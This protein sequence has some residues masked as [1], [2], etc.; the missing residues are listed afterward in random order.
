MNIDCN[1]KGHNKAGTSPCPGLELW[2]ASQGNSFPFW[3]DLWHGCATY[4]GGMCP[5][6][7][8]GHN[9]HPPPWRRIIWKPE[10]F[11]SHNN[12]LIS[13]FLLSKQR[14]FPAPQVPLWNRS[15]ILPSPIPNPTIVTVT[16]K[17][18]TEHF[19]HHV[20]FIIKLTTWHHFPPSLFT[21]R[22]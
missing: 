17:H 19:C 13:F 18:L 21:S 9:I 8:Q 6:Q 14:K 11:G 2:L 12:S 5:L 16:H 1:C 10:E 7:R 20:S 3:H 4:L 15:W 22:I